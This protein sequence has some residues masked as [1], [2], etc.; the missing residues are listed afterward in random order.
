WV[1]C[2]PADCF[3]FYIGLLVVVFQYSSI[4]PDLVMLLSGLSLLVRT[5]CYDI[6]CSFANFDGPRERFCLKILDVDPDFPN[7]G[8][9][10]Q[11]KTYS[12]PLPQCRN[13]ETHTTVQSS[14]SIKNFTP[15]ETSLSG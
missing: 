14:I 3:P 7:L 4:D 15:R 12:Y 11:T 9:D 6:H 2:D 10:V 1:W 8:H 13:K 5:G